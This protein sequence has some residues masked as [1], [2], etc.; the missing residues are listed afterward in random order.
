[1]NW[2]QTFQL[3]SAVLGAQ[4][5]I[6]GGRAEASNYLLQAGAAD[7]NA[8]V[9]RYMG[10]QALEASTM[11]Q[12]ALSREQRRFAGTQRAAV[13]QAGIG[14]RGSA[15]DVVA[16]DATLAELDRM[17]LAREGEV[18]FLSAL[19]Q[20]DFEEMNARMYRSSA[21][22]SRRSGNLG[23]ARSLLGGAATIWGGK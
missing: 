16:Q 15:A 4:A 7:Y 18:R 5:S 23:A 20:A 8:L 9:T 6:A 14:T 3:A 2:A 11:R 21:S 1:M 19:T 10:R 13:A 17:N 22:A 12:L